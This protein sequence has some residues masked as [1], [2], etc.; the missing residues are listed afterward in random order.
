[1][2]T[3]EQIKNRAELAVRGAKIDIVP[4]PGP[5]G[6]A[7]LLIDN[8]HA[9]GVA[10]FLRDHAALS[11]DF[12]SNVTGIDWLDRVVKKTT[13]VKQVVDGVEKEVDQA[14][15][16]KI[17]GYL[18]A[19]YHLF[20]IKL[21]HGP[22]IIRM[23][24]ANRADQVRLPSL[25]PVWRSAE[26]QEREIF[27]LYG[28]HFDGHPDL[29]RILMWDEFKDHPMRKDYVQPDDFEWEPTPHDEVLERAKTH[30]APR[31]QADGAEQITAK[32]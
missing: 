28:I 27:D 2:E 21:K 16:E 23:R 3:L 4:N 31:P 15:E 9:V 14:S 25:T 32:P 8:E 17:P 18:E 1:M 30:Y 24:T 11:F 12:C 5:S 22:V 13:K 7:S 6:Q 19:V 20:S 26:L 29:R 10:T